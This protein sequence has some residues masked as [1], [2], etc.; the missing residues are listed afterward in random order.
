MIT[1]KTNAYTNEERNAL[2]FVLRESVKAFI[3]KYCD[4]KVRCAECAYRHV[5]YD[6]L[7]ARDYMT[8]LTEVTKL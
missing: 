2:D 8:K 4:P 5:C 6:V 1:I 3:N 7:K